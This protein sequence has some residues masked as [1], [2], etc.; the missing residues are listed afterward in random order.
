[1]GE[2][3]GGGEWGEWGS[4]GGELEGEGG[5]RREIV[6]QSMLISSVPMHLSRILS[7]PSPTPPLPSYPASN[8]S[9]V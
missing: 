1:M 4:L 3:W 6:H 2:S 8:R 5:R 9:R 7:V